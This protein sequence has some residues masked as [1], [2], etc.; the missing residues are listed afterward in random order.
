MKKFLSFAA[1]ALM[2]AAS[3]LTLT[4]C[5]DDD[6]KDN[7]NPAADFSIVGTWYVYEDDIESFEGIYVFN[8][9]NSGTYQ[10][11]DNDNGQPYGD[12]ESFTYQ[13]EGNKLTINS[14]DEDESLVMNINIKSA[15]EFTWTDG[16]DSLTFKKQP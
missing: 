5:G 6:D 4:A 14:N 13:L 10:D 3:A 8:A 15:T 1:F 9:N 7:N 12:A 2:L 16:H 11:Y